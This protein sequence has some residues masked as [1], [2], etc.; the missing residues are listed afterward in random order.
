MLFFFAVDLMARA[1]L[2]LG[3]LFFFV[4]LFAA[5]RLFVVRFVVVTFL[6][7]VLFD[8]EPFLLFFLEAMDEV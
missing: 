7:A 6:L 1:V 8:I 2:P 4:V 3:A 5:G